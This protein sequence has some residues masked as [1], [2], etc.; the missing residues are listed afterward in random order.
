VL[1]AINDLETEIATAQV[2]TRGYVITGGDRYLQ[3]QQAAAGHC[4][5]KL[6]ALRQLI[7]DP[8]QQAR[9]ARLEAQVNELLQ[10]FPQV[11]AAART[12]VVATVRRDMVNHGEDL[13]D[14]VRALIAEME[15][16]EQRMLQERHRQAQGVA[17]F[18]QVI[19][20]TGTLVSLIVFLSVLWGLNQSEKRQQQARQAIQASEDRLRFALD[21]IETGA[22]DLDLVDYSAHRSLKHDQIFGYETLLP[23]WTYEMFLK[24]V[25]PEDQA[26]V[27]QKFRHAMA[28]K[29]DWHFQCRIIRRDGQQRWILGSG[30][31]RLDSN[32]EPRR[33]AGIVQDITE[34]QQAQ[35]AMIAS[36]MRYRR[37]FE[38]A[39]DGILILD[40]E[41]GMVVDV[42]P[43]LIELLG[44]TRE[45]F[46][47]EKVWELGFFKDVVTNEANFA[48]LQEKKYIRY[49]DMAL[50]GHDGKRHEVEFV[51]NVY[52]VDGGKVIQ[53]N[54]RDISERKQ[55]EAV[56]AVL[57][58]LAETKALLQ[59]ALDHSQAGIAIADAP[60][61]KLRYVNRAGLLIGG[62]TQAELVAG[63]DANQYVASWNLLN[64]DGTALAKEEV[65]LTRAILFGEQNTR[66]FIIS[67]SELDGRIVLANAAPIRNPAGEITAAIVVFLD[68]TEQKRAEELLRQNAQELRARNEELSRFNRLMTGRE[69][70]VIELKQ[71]VNELAAQLGQPWPYPLAFL[72]AAAAEVVRTATKP[73]EQ[74]SK[75]PETPKGTSL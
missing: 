73:S 66:E 25:V 47:G 32:G 7:V 2:H 5:A 45:V 75:N 1:N 19:I 56:L 53:C 42:N 8:A 57:A 59:A 61:G 74:N 50:E 43:Y 26:A 3:S 67:P 36:E 31:H 64:L 20:T 28:S 63:V 58:V 30:R 49:E 6:P 60:S 51:S 55:A 15:A 39:R 37:L 13:M 68:I 71:Q 72:D 9:S 24:H 22:W 35:A 16:A 40:A 65:P 17:R 48:E 41:T 4:R 29:G 52:L 14:D 46:L 54:I 34:R 38:A 33:L 10:W 18:T 69:L 12:G 44:V 21:E 27:D 70:C 62:G 23:R 11:I